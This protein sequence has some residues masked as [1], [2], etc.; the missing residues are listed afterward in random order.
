MTVHLTLSGRSVS[1]TLP[2]G[3]VDDQGEV[4]R[5]GLMRPATG[6]DELMAQQRIQETGVPAFSI[7]SR[8]SQVVFQ[9]GAIAP[10]PDVIEQL[11]LPDFDY[12]IS[13]YNQINPKEAAV[14]MTVTMGGYPLEQLYQEVAF[15]AMHFH[16]SRHD[17][18]NLE[19]SERQ[20]W[21]KEIARLLMQRQAS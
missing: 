1:F 21:V 18:L 13:L 10:T 7:F 8:L 14:S 11:F 9:L 15:I 6:Q 5:E 4:H 12:L 20:Q 3:F 17:I 16:W 2:Q 19:H